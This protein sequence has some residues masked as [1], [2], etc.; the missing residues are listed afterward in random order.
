LLTQKISFASFLSQIDNT[1][2]L[3]IHGANDLMVPLKTT[4][5]KI[6]TSVEKT[7]KIAL[8][9]PFE[10][11]YNRQKSGKYIYEQVCSLFINTPE[12]DNLLIQLECL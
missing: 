11:S 2:I 1:P 5:D 9:T 12:Y 3:F 4:F 6:W 8:I 7:N 10:H